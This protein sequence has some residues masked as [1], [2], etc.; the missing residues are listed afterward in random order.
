MF[1]LVRELLFSV[2]NIIVL[3]LNLGSKTILGLLELGVLAVEL[4]QVEFKVSDG[5]FKSA[6]LVGQLLD[7]SVVVIEVALKVTVFVFGF[8]DL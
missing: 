7:L 5:F 1:L 8:K 4:I 2:S 6:F 3:V